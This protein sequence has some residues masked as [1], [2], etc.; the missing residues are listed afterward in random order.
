MIRAATCDDIPRIVELGS[1]SIWEGPYKDQ[2]EDNPSVTRELTE[3]LLTLENAKVLVSES[4]GVI[5]GLFAFILF[6][7]YFSGQ[8]TAGEMI[9]Y[10]IPEARGQASLELLW[11]AEKLAFEMGAKRM[12]LTA[13]TEQVGKIYE[14]IKY[15]QV[16]CTYQAKLENRVNR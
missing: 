10:V 8:L 11:A 15:V 12:Q 6:P 14:R 4:D 16:E 9:W 3:K 2:L 1:R 7:H 13:P 5:N